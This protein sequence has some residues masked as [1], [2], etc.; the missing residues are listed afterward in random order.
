MM[1]DLFDIATVGILS[2]RLR[3]RKHLPLRRPLQPVQATRE[4]PADIVPPAHRLCQEET[5]T[6]HF[7]RRVVERRFVK[8]QQKIASAVA[9]AGP[10]RACASRQY[11]G[12]A[13]ARIVSSQPP[14]P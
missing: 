11:C 1:A 13:A 10:K 7:K 2:R 14:K 5:V 9:V 3:A 6:G 12:S 8:S 4:T